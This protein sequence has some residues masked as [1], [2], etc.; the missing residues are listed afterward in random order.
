LRGILDLPDETMPH[1]GERMNPEEFHAVF[2]ENRDLDRETI[3]RGRRMFRQ[4]EKLR[5]C[6]A[7]VVDCLHHQGVVHGQGD[8]R[9][10]LAYLDEAGVIGKRRALLGRSRSVKDERKSFGPCG[11]KILRTP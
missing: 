6:L 1:M 2:A 7:R 5:Q 9:V 4:S 8:E 10:V 3:H 11:P